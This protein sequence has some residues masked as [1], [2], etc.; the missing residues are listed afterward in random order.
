MQILGFMQSRSLYLS[1]STQSQNCYKLGLHIKE[2][3]ST[4]QHCCCRI[5]WKNVTE[6]L[7]GCKISCSWWV[8]AT[9]SA[10]T[11]A[12]VRGVYCW[13]NMPNTLWYLW[14]YKCLYSGGIGRN[15]NLQIVSICQSQV[16][17]QEKKTKQNKTETLNSKKRL[18]FSVAGAP[19]PVCSCSKRPGGHNAG[20]PCG[21]PCFRQK[22]HLELPQGAVL[23]LDKMGQFARHVR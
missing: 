11:A 23:C 15:T 17:P 13:R 10:L 3:G 9:W 21:S 2:S 5:G 12:G 20:V 19:S 18:N 14:H 22:H 4:L 1:L 6:I 7:V 16:S 8:P